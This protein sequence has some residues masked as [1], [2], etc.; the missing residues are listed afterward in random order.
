MRKRVEWQW[1]LTEVPNIE[2]GLGI[3]K[4]QPGEICVQSGVWRAEVWNTS[5]CADT[6][7]GLRLSV[8][9][10]ADECGGTLP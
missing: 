4:V 10:V 9:L 6:G 5:G 2:D 3:W 8:M 7:A 1:I